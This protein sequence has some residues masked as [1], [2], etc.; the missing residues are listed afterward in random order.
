MPLVEI[1]DYGVLS[2]DF[3]PDSELLASGSAGGLVRFWSVD[4]DCNL[5]ATLAG[6]T[7]VVSGVS[8]SPNGRFLAS[9]SHDGS[10]RLWGIR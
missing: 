7:D 2:L 1:Q 5:I 10:V 4:D 9:S 8:F 3:S 6:H